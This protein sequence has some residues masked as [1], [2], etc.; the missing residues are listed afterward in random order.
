MPNFGSFKPYVVSDKKIFKDFKNF[1]AMATR[2][3]EE[4]KFFQEILKRTIAG[5][6]LWNFIKIRYVVSEKMFKE[7]VNANK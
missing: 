6:F 4:I 1:V 5:T 3:F 2:I 7:K